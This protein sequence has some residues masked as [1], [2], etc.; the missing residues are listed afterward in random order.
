MKALVASLR[1]GKPV[2]PITS[3]PTPLMQSLSALTGVA[4]TADVV[5]T[6]LGPLCK[7]DVVQVTGLTS[8]PSLCD[9]K[10]VVKDLEASQITVLFP[11][12]LHLQT[13]SCLFEEDPF[14]R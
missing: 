10:G 2:E 6:D 13:R 8:S 9:K 7:G 5:T 1:D 14:E 4:R 3:N 12:K 11:G